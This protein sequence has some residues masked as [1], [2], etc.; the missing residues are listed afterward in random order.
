[1]P[2][3][4]PV[5]AGP[6]RASFDLAPELRGAVERQEF[7]VEYQPIVDLRK[8]QPVGV[9]ALVR[10]RHPIR[11]TVPPA[12]FLPL[13]EETGDIVAIGAWVLDRS[14]R[15]ARAWQQAGTPNLFLSVNL[16]AA[17]LADAGL[18]RSVEVALQTCGLEPRHL[19]LEIAGAS[20]DA[21]AATLGALRKLGVSVALDDFG[22]A[23]SLMDVRSTPCDV[24][25]IDRAFVV[26][27]AGAPGDSAFAEALLSV[28]QARSLTTVAKGVEERDQARRLAALACDQ[29]QGYL[30]GK[31]LGAEGIGALLARSR[32]GPAT[33]RRPT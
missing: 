17:Q 14:C 8:S 13:A 27:V 24:V 10:W 28:G 19:V 16:S 3:I 5:A 9:E 20:G 7:M 12:D 22:G 4:P 23:S 30:Y 2:A 18:R 11:G 25:K 15:Q 29:G 31:P 6:K 21:G 1:M 32:L 26:D 33:G